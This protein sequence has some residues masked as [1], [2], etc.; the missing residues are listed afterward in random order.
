M[1]AKRIPFD[2]SNQVV[3][4]DNY[5]SFVFNL[6]RYFEQLGQPTCVVRNDRMDVAVLRGWR[7]RAIVISPGP[8]RP[9]D[10][11][12]SLD[13]VRQLYRDVPILGVC[14]G[15]QVI[16]E[17]LGGR[18]AHAAEPV[19]GRASDLVHVGEGVFEGLPS[20][21][22]VG[23]YH[24]LGVEADTLPDD[25][26]VTARTDD[27][28]IMAIA[29][30]AYNVVGLQFHPESILTDHG[31]TLLANFMR[32][33]GIDVVASATELDGANT[34]RIAAPPPSPATPVTF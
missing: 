9:A 22:R 2:A 33:S 5:D 27:G 6:A 17:A 34:R 12:V 8:G 3:V 14:L 29:H 10:A 20:P 26:M 19:H 4:I 21:L 28:T 1:Q 13:V 25:L 7:P 15:H 24:S 32:Q 31:Y 23:R 30:R 18:V 11:G 16:A